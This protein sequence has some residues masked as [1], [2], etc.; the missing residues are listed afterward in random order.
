MVLTKNNEESW[1]DSEDTGGD[2]DKINIY[3]L[4]IIIIGQV[5]SISNLIG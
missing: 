5:F 2:I 3:L 4:R 1:L